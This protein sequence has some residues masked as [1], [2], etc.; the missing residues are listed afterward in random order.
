MM[1]SWLTE[2]GI[3]AMNPAR[4]VKTERFSRT[5]GKT[6]AF[7]EGEVQRLLGRDRDI[8]AHRPARSRPARRLPLLPAPFFIALRIL[9]EPAVNLSSIKMIRV[10]PFVPLQ[11]I[12][13]FFQS[14]DVAENISDSLLT[15]RIKYTT[16]GLGNQLE[17]IQGWIPAVVVHLVH[18]GFRPTAIFGW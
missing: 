8:D 6:P 7:V 17:F 3:L 18:V 9:L 10:E 12:H 4:E 1:F 13:C 11:P 16:Y 14:I 15:L 2:K 5:E